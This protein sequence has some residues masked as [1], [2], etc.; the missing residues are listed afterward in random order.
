MPFFRYLTI[1]LTIL[2]LSVE[3]HT[4]WAHDAHTGTAHLRTWTV[5][6]GGQPMVASFLLFKEGK[7]FLEDAE[8]RVKA[9]PLSD[10]STDDQVYV[11]K[12]YADIQRLNAAH[13]HAHHQ[14]E[15]RAAQSGGAIALVLLGVAVLMAL[16]LWK[17]ARDPRLVLGG[18]AGVL[19]LT[20]FG[21]H[22]WRTARSLTDPLVVDSAFAPFKPG[23]V[24][25]FW[26]DD[27]F[28]VESNG[29]AHHEMMTGITAWQQQV[30]IPQ[31][32]VG[33][34]AWPIPLN[35]ALADTVI[36]VDSIHFTR[37]AIAVAVNGVPIF[38]P[39]TNTG[40]DAFLD[41]QLDEFGGHSGRADD[42]HYH[43]APL[44]LYGQTASTRPI[45]YALDGYAVYGDA[46]PE[47]GPMLP[48]DT[49]HGHFGTEG[50][51]HYH[52]S[53]VAPYMIGNMVGQVT[54]DVTHQIVPQA[55]ANPVRPALT[56]LQGAVI[57]DCTP[58][59][60]N[61]GY[62]LVYTVA[63]VTDS[64]VYSWT[65]DGTYTYNYYVNGALTTDTYQDFVPC[66]ISTAMLDRPVAPKDL[67]LFP[68]PATSSVSVRVGGDIRPQDVRGITIVDLKGEVL[69]NVPR[70]TGT[71]D[72]RG[73]APGTYLMHVQLPTSTVTKKLIIR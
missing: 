2:V 7:V 19:V 70:Y 35:P 6:E 44:H 26:D 16:F 67:S 47:G 72:T 28:Y 65:T 41:G 24:N 27:Y 37:G 29:I 3:P 66:T 17:R 48:L 50:V 34:N 30:P 23:G 42:Y 22:Q 40:V 25:T 43:I 32:Y 8:G 73:L 68:V 46:E 12:R 64:I 39:H 18:M 61:N 57:T 10:L 1:A 59:A 55:H 53:A 11:K 54:E 5:Q 33:A 52:G 13:D 58:N 31:C 20:G 60:D 36:P 38:N 21:L 62:T 14:P 49:N 51:Y 69:F 63:G 15:E 56:P 71:I 4:A 45:A 9:Y